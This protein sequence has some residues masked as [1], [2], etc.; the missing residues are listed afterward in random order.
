M[1]GTCQH[2]KKNN[3][4]KKFNS[5]IRLKKSTGKLDLKISIEKNG[6]RNTIQKF[7]AKIG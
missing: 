3:V 5:Q 4:I 6:I 7:K 2:I 1:L